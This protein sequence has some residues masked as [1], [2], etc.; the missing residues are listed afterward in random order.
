M[1]ASTIEI[2]HD[3]LRDPNGI[4]VLIRTL[5]QILIDKTF[6]VWVFWSLEDIFTP[7]VQELIR[8]IPYLYHLRASPGYGAHADPSH[9]IFR[10]ASPQEH[11]RT[12]TITKISE[13][14]LDFVGDLSAYDHPVAISSVEKIAYRDAW[15]AGSHNLAARPDLTPGP[16]DLD[17]WAHT[18]KAY[19]ARVSFI[20]EQSTNPDVTT[21]KHILDQF[22][23]PGID[24]FKVGPRGLCEPIKFISLSQEKP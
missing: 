14:Y 20:H 22:T 6:P 18:L 24:E 8:Y 5:I 21:V 12:E 7:F 11:L 10:M 4:S 19:I 13:K 23:K 17:I 15:I 2:T 3:D 1:G 9:P 16:L